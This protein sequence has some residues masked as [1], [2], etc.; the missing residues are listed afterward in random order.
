MPEL[1]GKAMALALL[2]IDLILLGSNLRT[3]SHALIASEKAFVLMLHAAI[4][5]NDEILCCLI[6]FFYSSVSPM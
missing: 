3:S 5:E 6:I 4:F 2:Y 1:I